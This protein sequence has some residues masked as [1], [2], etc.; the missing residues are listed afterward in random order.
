MEQA[1][2]SVDYQ[3]ITTSS[4]NCFFL[5]LELSMCLGVVIWAIFQY[6]DGN[7]DRPRAISSE[8]YGKTEYF[9]EFHSGEDYLEVRP[10]Q[11]LQE[12]IKKLS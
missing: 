6:S 8:P 10:D 7:Q 9:E 4:W 3:H 2:F 11:D 12:I 5:E 1:G